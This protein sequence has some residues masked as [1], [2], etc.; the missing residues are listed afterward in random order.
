MKVETMS[1]SLRLVAK[2]IVAVS[3]TL[4]CVE[5]AY[6][7]VLQIVP[8]N[9][10]PSDSI[11]AVFIIPLMCNSFDRVERFE[12]LI[13]IVVT[14]EGSSNCLLPN[15]S[16]GSRVEF[17]TLPAATY[18]VELVSRDPARATNYRVQAVTSFVVSASNRVGVTP[19]R[20]DAVG[21]IALVLAPTDAYQSENTFVKFRL[22]DAANRAVSGAEY[23]FS[24]N[25]SS[26]SSVRYCGRFDPVDKCVFDELSGDDGIIDLKLIGPSATEGSRFRTW[27]VRPYVPLGAYTYNP[28]YVTVGY[29]DVKRLAR[30][31]PVIEYE[32]LFDDA[33]SASYPQPTGYFLAV[34]ESDMKLL[35]ELPAHFQR[36]YA[37]FFGVREGTGGAQPVC[38]FLKLLPT[39]ARYFHWFTLNATEC[40]AKRNDPAY[41][42]EGTPFW[43]Y[44]A[45]ADGGCPRDTRG[46][47]RYLFEK[48]GETFSVRY[49]LLTKL[50]N[51]AGGSVVNNYKTLDVKN[52][53]I[54]F[55]VPD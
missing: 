28:A 33:R 9:P 8:F 2:W 36:T 40:A 46:V 50:K 51:L 31:I 48:D 32:V 23:G 22:T 42:Y 13:T 4:L 29:I 43:A 10:R 7:Q 35:D 1:Y 11:A 25:D 5:S 30:V 54:A 52:D 16:T 18:S 39:Q 45:R 27:T 44:P 41:V 6:S 24:V 55:C 21:S 15:P 34:S 38:R 26:T 14:D 12:K 49:S 19:T 20:I 47:T 3:L 17:G 37:A 53:G